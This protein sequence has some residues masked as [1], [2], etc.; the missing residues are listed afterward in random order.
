MEDALTG[1]NYV[2]MYVS[3]PLKEDEENYM[4]RRTVAKWNI[5]HICSVSTNLSN[6]ESLKFAI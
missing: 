2:R 4:D 3:A 6:T 1:R 5:Y